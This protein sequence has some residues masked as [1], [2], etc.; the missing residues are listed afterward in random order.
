MSMNEVT[1][2]SLIARIAE[3]NAREAVSHALLIEQS[4]AFNACDTAYRRKI[5]AIQA[6]RELIERDSRNHEAE[7]KE[8]HA[9]LAKGGIYTFTTTAELVKD[10][11]LEFNVAGCRMTTPQPV[12]RLTQD[13]VGIALLCSLLPI[14]AKMGYGPNIGQLDRRALLRLVEECESQD[15]QPLEVTCG[16]Q[17]EV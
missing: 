2:A 4:N 17:E 6:E 9:A 5:A 7:L 3:I 10:N 13:D 16:Q 12:E 15:G 1:K 11:R 8:L 14:I